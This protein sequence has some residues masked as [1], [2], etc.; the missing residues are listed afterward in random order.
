MCLYLGV[1][2]RC[3]GIY[4]MLVIDSY[5]IVIYYNVYYKEASIVVFLVMCWLLCRLV[6][7]G[8]CLGYKWDEPALIGE[9]G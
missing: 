3:L 4:H 5:A 7:L 6:K 2:E 9:D 8:I 1:F